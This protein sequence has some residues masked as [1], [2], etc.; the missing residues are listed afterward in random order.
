MTRHL[1]KLG[2]KKE[3]LIRDPMTRIAVQYPT[4]KKQKTLKPTK[5]NP[6]CRWGEKKGLGCKS[7]RKS[8]CEWKSSSV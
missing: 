2:M 3:Q 5:I 7:D 8:V 1:L 6:N 4:G